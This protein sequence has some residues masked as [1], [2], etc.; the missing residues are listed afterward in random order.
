MSR[1][2]PSRQS[3]PSFF[4]SWGPFVEFW[5]CLKRRLRTELSLLDL[6]SVLHVSTNVLFV[7]RTEFPLHGLRIPWTTDP[8][9]EYT[10]AKEARD[11]A[12]LCPRATGGSCA[13]A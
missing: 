9:R 11:I 12:M 6:V 13:A 7:Q 1:F 3:F 2:F 4:L 8:D 10:R 5:W